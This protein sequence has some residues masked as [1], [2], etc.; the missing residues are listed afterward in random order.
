VTD[1]REQLQESVGDR[2]RIGRQLGRGGM[3]TVFLAQDLKLNRAVAVKVLR[4]ELAYSVGAE[5][6]QR[7]IHVAAELRHPHIVP[8]YDAC[9]AGGLLYYVM[10]YVEGESLQA[11]L[12][13][14]RQLPIDDVFLIGREV[15][16]A[17]DYAH[18]HGIVHRDIKPANILLAEGHAWVAD[19]GIARAVSVAAGEGL[20]STGLAI[21]TPGYMSPEQVAA[22]DGIDGRSDVYSLGCVVYEMLAGEPPFTGPTPEAIL[23]RQ[24]T[25]PP[26]PLRT[27]RPAVRPWVEEAVRRALDPTPVDRFSTAGTFVTALE[28]THGASADRGSRPWQR[29]RW[30]IATG[31]T[32]GVAAI[33]V[34]YARGTQARLDDN[35]VLVFPLRVSGS[36]LPRE[37]GEDIAQLLGVELVGTAPLKLVEGGDWLDPGSRSDM[38]RLSP[39]TL[40]EVA[41]RQRAAYY[42]DGSVVTGPDS[43]RVVLR[44]HDVAGDSLVAYAPA[45]G[46][47]AD[48]PLHALALRAIAKLL[49]PILEPGRQVDVS[50]LADRAPAA[51][52]NFLQG[53]RE[54]RRGAIARALDLY[55]VALRQDSALAIAAVRGAQAASW[56]QRNDEALEL[57]TRAVADANLLPSRYAH[58]ARGIAHYQHGAADSA[59][60]ELQEALRSDTSWAEGWMA[61]GEVYYHLMPEVSAPPDSLATKAFTAVRRID[62]TFEPIL[63]HLAALALR[64]GEV[65]RADTLLQELARSGF[66]SSFTRVGAVMRRCIRDGPRAVDWRDAV[67]QDATA[68]VGLSKFLAGDMAQPACARAGSE[69]VWDNDSAAVAARW[70]ALLV[71]NGLDVAS[72]RYDEAVHLLES[73]QAVTLPGGALLLHD[74]V[75]G[76]PVED[77]AN[78]VAEHYG[79]DYSRIGSRR[80]SLLGEWEAHHGRANRVRAIAGAFAA[81]R[82]SVQRQA[83]GEDRR[84]DSLL[85]RVMAAHVTLTSGDTSG[86]ISQLRALRPTAAYDGLEWQPWESL[87]YERLT[88]ARLLLARGEAR[89]AIHVAAQLD[90]P[91]PVIYL[92]YLRPS[93]ELRL[94][95]AQMIGDA[96]LATQ[97][98]ERLARLNA[99]S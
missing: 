36:G 94:R 50:P 12:G 31:C 62:P 98:R 70:G 40:R 47:R 84:I 93:I 23:A 65:A 38:G 18:A 57:A 27:V 95:A 2:Y 87:G 80:L 39:G 91:Q 78:R 75:A 77:H 15:A 17:L 25:E 85:A 9:E 54:Y 24:L 79:T 13:R 5:R 41:T 3:A 30:L 60:I 90:H 49:L 69:A 19:F 43:T 28:R 37:E 16:D 58:F 20:T 8:L 71:L 68:L 46:R 33:A 55:R 6:F 92:L 64:R 48:V 7:E 97:M 56:L 52:A 45:A 34:A 76:A 22:M 29:R 66:D 89:E 51:V 73:S 67:R 83:H 42:I 1:I 82:D 61:V 63:P 96:R 99:A 10:Q 35:R 86:A 14:E 26:R 32:V 59:L 88:L 72:G 4:P 21:G 74:A 11:R 81:K 44:L 53:E